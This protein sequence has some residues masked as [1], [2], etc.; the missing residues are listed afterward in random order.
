MLADRV[1]HEIAY[2]QIYQE[3]IEDE[4]R[5]LKEVLERPDC[6]FIDG[7]AVADFFVASYDPDLSD[8][9]VH[10]MDATLFDLRPP[11]VY[12]W[13][14]YSWTEIYQHVLDPDMGK[15][16][17]IGTLIVDRSR[18][19]VTPAFWHDSWQQIVDFCDEQPGTTLHGI[20]FLGI[21]DSG[22]LNAV[23]SIVFL[24]HNGRLTLNNRDN[25][26]VIPIVNRREAQDIMTNTDEDE[27]NEQL[28]DL[29][30]WAD[31]FMRVPL[32]TLSLLNVKNVTTEEHKPAEKV[33]RKRIL[34]GKRPLVNYHTLN[35]ALPGTRQTSTNTRIE[36]ENNKQKTTMPLGLVRGHFADY[37]KGK[38]L[39]GKHHG[40]YLIPAHFR[41]SIENGV[42]V[43]NYKPKIDKGRADAAIHDAVDVQ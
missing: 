16:R 12:T 25:D 2:A 42:V 28:Y 43:K 40:V 8:P 29:A 14:E 26:A 34:N 7:D 31:S 18:A 24:D 19:S 32:L 36:G 10:A 13:I 3:N 30:M 9:K 41:G 11:S 20:H 5:W 27:A 15:I 33:Q 39:F 17:R 6:V 21:K 38:G 22:V 23:T 35:V 1:Y 37:T 4:Y